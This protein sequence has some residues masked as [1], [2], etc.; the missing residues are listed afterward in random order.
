MTVDIFSQ[1]SNDLIYSQSEFL[2]DEKLSK[3]FIAF[4]FC[5]A[6]VSILQHYFLFFF[7]YLNISANYGT[8]HEIKKYHQQAKYISYRKSS[9]RNLS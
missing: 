7:Y 6:C 1:M 9:V 5:V 2:S 4:S 8:I 3:I